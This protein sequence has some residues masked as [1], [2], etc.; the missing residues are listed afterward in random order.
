MEDNHT[1]KS[2][3]KRTARTGKHAGKG[4]LRHAVQNKAM[5]T[6]SGEP[7]YEKN[8]FGKAIDETSV[9]LLMKEILKP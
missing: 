5:T 6:E 7:V 3:A 2:A 9:G 4:I 1:V 8:G